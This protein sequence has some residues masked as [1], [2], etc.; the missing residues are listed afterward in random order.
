MQLRGD[1][2]LV[3]FRLR[4]SSAFMSLLDAAARTRHLAR[5]KLVRQAFA[6]YLS[7][8]VEPGPPA[9]P[10]NAVFDLYLPAPML[11]ALTA[12]ARAE[13]RSRAEL[14]RLAITKFLEQD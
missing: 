9:E 14:A 6:S 2:D 8:P 5:A 4:A 12:R 7:T 10:I 13:N 3:H 11:E 1:T